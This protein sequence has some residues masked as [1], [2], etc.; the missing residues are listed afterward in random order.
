MRAQ[1]ELI[2]LYRR[3]LW[4][5]MVEEAIA[6]RYT[7]QKMRC[8]VHLS[9]GQ[10]AAATAV[11]SALSPQDKIFSNHRCH[12]HYLA[13]GGN[14]EAMLCELHGRKGGCCE[15][16][17]GSMH[18]FDMQA[19]VASSIPI[20]GASIPH[21]VG[22]A[23]ANRQQKRDGC[24]V[25]YLGDG[26]VEE[27]VFHESL[28]FASTHDLGVLFVVENNHYSVYTSLQERQPTLPLGRFAQAHGIP[29]EQVENAGVEVA[30]CAALRMLEIVDAQQ[31]PA[32]LVLDTY[33]FY[34][35]CGPERDDHLEYRP[36]QESEWALARCPV[37]LARRSLI[38]QKLWSSQLE[39]Q[40][41]S[42]YRQKIQ[43]AF[44][45]ALAAPFPE[46]QNLTTQ[47]FA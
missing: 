30:H 34:S 27:G 11:C 40:I 3:M 41:Q 37:T 44:E 39:E 35:H 45:Q 14:L 43:N 22:W 21:A 4:I 12:A 42:R 25:A 24:V 1:R 15:G 18:L 31:G 28:N 33:R 9:I 6:E 8:P 13:K 47:V 23:L 2:D 5:R 29:Y 26:A 17:G 46:P 16:R 38:E 7:D 36:K 19:G 20:V 32:C 10:E